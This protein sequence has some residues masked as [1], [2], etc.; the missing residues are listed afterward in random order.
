MEDVHVR[1]GSISTCTLVLVLITLSTI[2]TRT[3]YISTCTQVLS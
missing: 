1:H 2:S 3:M